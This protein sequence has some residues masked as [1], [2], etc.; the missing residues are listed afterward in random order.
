MCRLIEITNVS[1]FYN[2]LSLKVKLLLVNLTAFNRSALCY[3][4][5]KALFR[6]R[7]LT[8]KRGFI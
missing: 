4:Y 6:V 7:I 3:H 8:M 2:R 1:Y 5:L